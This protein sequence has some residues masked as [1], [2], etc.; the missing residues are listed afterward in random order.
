M[1]AFFVHLYSI[2]WIKGNRILQ[3]EC[4]KICSENKAK[5]LR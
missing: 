1:M 2:T 4:N 3:D 5:E